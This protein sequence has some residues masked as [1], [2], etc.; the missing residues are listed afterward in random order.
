LVGKNLK[1]YFTVK[2]LYQS[3]AQFSRTCKI[4]PFVGEGKR[5]HMRGGVEILAHGA[6]LLDIR[7]EKESIH[8]F[9]S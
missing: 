1:Q 4:K 6:C 7:L 2:S 8:I 9:L 3:K 5:W